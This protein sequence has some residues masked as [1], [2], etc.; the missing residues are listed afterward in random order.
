MWQCVTQ[1]DCLSSSWVAQNVFES[2]RYKL[3]TTGLHIGIDTTYEL[4]EFL[5]QYI[6]KNMNLNI[7]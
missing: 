3:Y 4:A 5:N 2:G 7:A 1:S 6:V